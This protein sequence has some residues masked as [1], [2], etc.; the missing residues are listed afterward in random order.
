M[1]TLGVRKQLIE[2]HV[3]RWWVDWEADACA[4]LQAIKEPEPEQLDALTDRLWRDH[5]AQGVWLTM[6]EAAT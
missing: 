6:V 2:D 3:D 4:V 1:Q 5:T